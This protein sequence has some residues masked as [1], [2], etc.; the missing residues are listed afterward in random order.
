MKKIVFKFKRKNSLLTTELWKPEAEEILYVVCSEL[1]FYLRKTPRTSSI[2]D[3]QQ[4]ILLYSFPISDSME[5]FYI[6]P[7][8]S[9]QSG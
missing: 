4:H 8:A 2:T 1:H 5:S 7:E 9:I 3:K 6:V